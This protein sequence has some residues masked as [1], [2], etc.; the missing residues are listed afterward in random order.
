MKQFIDF[1]QLKISVNDN[2]GF[3]ILASRTLLGIREE[4]NKYIKD[5]ES[6]EN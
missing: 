1:E 6:D 4:F 3:K 5:F 2:D